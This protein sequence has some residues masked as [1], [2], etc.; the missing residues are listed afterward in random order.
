MIDLGLSRT[1]W[2]SNYLPYGRFFIVTVPLI[3]SFLTQ[4]A[5]TASVLYPQAGAGTRLGR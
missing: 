1:S 2:Y 4:D 5:H 3:R